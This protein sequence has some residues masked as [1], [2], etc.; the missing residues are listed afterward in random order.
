MGMANR[1]RLMRRALQRFFFPLLINALTC[2]RIPIRVARLVCCQAIHHHR[3]ERHRERNGLL[4]A[5]DREADGAKDLGQPFFTSLESMPLWQRSN[6]D[7]DV[8][9]VALASQGQSAFLQS[10]LWEDHSVKG[11]AKEEHPS[12]TDVPSVVLE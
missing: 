1:A 8:N 4:E 6:C 11:Q 2:C 10:C 7:R 3:S 12:A 9:W 5:T